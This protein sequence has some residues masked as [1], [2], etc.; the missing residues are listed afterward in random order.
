MLRPE[1]FWKMWGLIQ[2]RFG[3][4]ALD[5]KSNKF[6]PYHKPNNHPLYINNQSNHPPSIKKH[7]LG[8]INNRITKL[9]HDQ[10]SFNQTSPLYIEALKNSGFTVNIKY[11]EPASVELKNNKQ[12]NKCKN[13]SKRK[14]NIIWFNLPYNK[15]V[16][17]NIQKAFFNLTV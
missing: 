6:F 13:K 4:I 16:Q 14:R 1:V 17:T 8:M 7:L 12:R 2:K 15:E 10:N 3:T 9:S 5:L 11:N